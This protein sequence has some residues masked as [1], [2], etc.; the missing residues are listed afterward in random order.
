M[1]MI[2]GKSILEVRRVRCC[3]KGHCVVDAPLEPGIVSRSVRAAIRGIPGDT[4]AARSGTGCQPWEEVK[5]KAGIGWIIHLDR[6]APRLPVVN[7]MDQ[8]HIRAVRVSAVNRS[9]RL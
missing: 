6:L 8:E 5:V 7:R 3:I 1:S 4:D 2:A 9:S